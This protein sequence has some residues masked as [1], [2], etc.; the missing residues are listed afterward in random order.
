MVEPPNEESVMSKK[1]QNK[2][3][4]Q[5]PAPGKGKGAASQSGKN[6]GGRDKQGGPKAK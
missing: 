2:S 5:K 3:A 1:A 4:L 6:S